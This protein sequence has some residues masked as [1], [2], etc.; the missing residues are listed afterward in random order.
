MFVAA[1]KMFEN[2]RSSE[3][4]AVAQR[5]IHQRGDPVVFG[6]FEGLRPVEVVAG[7][8]RLREFFLPQRAA[9]HEQR[10]LRAKSGIWRHV[11]TTRGK[12]RRGGRRHTERGEDTVQALAKACTL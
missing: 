12:H 7:K 8:G 4:R 3:L 9:G 11:V 6:E 1:A 10:K 5:P 2:L